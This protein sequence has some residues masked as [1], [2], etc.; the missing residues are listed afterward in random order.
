MFRSS[1]F[2]LVLCLGLIGFAQTKD[3][4][5]SLEPGQTVEREIAGG[6]SHFYPIKLSAGQF[7]R[8]V[9]VQRGIDIVLELADPAGKEI[10]KADFSRNF[11]GQESLSFEAAVPGEYRLTLRPSS[12]TAP[13][14]SSTCGW[15]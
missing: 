11:G 3:E 14:G 9:A 10:W 8:V 13:K 6:E 7:M 12:K 1:L 4:I 5:R 2:P 15:K